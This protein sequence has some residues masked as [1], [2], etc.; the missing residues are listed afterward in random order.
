MDGKAKPYTIQL[1]VFRESIY[2]EVGKE[3][4]YC[5]MELI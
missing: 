5:G 2:I 1:G 3:I 4:Y